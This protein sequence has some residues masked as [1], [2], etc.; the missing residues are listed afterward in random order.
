M[1]IHSEIV[2]ENSYND[3]YGGKKIKTINPTIQSGS[4]VLFEN[5]ED[6][7]LAQEG[8]YPGVTYGTGGL[9]TQ[10]DFEDAICKLENGH[11]SFTF[12]SGMSAIVNS[13]MTFTKSGDEVLLCDNVYSPTSIFCHNVLE[14][15]GVMITHIPSSVGSDIDKYIT[16]KTTVIFMESPGSNTFEMQDIPAIVS[17]AKKNNIVTIIDNTWATPLYMRPL[18]LGVDVCIHSATKYICG[19]SDILLGCVT[20]NEK[21]YTQY[22]D[23]YH[24]LEKY[25]NPQD[26]YFALR[27]LR[28]LKV[29]LREHEKSA[30]DIAS[31]LQDHHLVDFVV[32][33]GLDSHPQHDI[34][35]R[36]YT[37]SG[38]LFG[39]V[40]KSSYTEEEIALFVNN[41]K[42]FGIGYSW[43]GF[44][45]LITVGKYKREGKIKYDGRHL[46]RLNVGLEGVQDLIEDL[47]SGFSYLT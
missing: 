12:S 11:A 41:L 42:K 31:W 39:F 9:S 36:D 46:V 16:N 19:Y 8:R 33:P 29:R 17:A 6:L 40:F 1:A 5:Y 30:L 27:G 26:C 34:W 13:L 20:V 4:T 3:S 25:A 43:G 2:S 7:K 35:K 22:N 21:H 47:K 23:F 10:K 32:H 45:S 18:D 28:S 44:K 37:G 38:G 24:S 14:K 15:Y